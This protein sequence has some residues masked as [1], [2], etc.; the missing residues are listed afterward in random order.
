M[1]ILRNNKASG[2]IPEAIEM[3]FIGNPKCLQTTVRSSYLVPEYSSL[4]KY[5]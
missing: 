1:L 5:K 2:A 4:L 3:L